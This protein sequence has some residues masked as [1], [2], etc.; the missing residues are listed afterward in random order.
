M[1]AS[2][3]LRVAAAQAALNALGGFWLPFVAL[4]FLWAGLQPSEYGLI[5]SAGLVVRVFVTPLAGIAADALRDR[6][7][8]GAILAVV[9]CGLFVL[10]ALAAQWRLGFWPILFAYTAA[11]AVHASV[12][13]II[14]A[15]T[16]RAAV[17]YG[18]TF[19][20]VR[21][22]GSAT[23]VLTTVIGG[24]YVGLTGPG[25]FMWT[26]AGFVLVQAIVFVN[27][28]PLR[29]ERDG[30]APA[31]ALALR[32]TF[33]DLGLLVSNRVFLAFL[34][35]T[36]LAQASHAVF[37]YFGTINFER[38]GFSTEYVGVLFGAGVV[39]EVL[40]LLAA[41]RFQK[42]VGPA[43][44]MLAGLA[45]AV[46]RWTGMSFDTGPWGALALQMLHAGTFGLVYLGTMQFLTRAVPHSLSASAQSLYAVIS[47]G[48]FMAIA[49]MIGG[50][51]YAQ[52]GATAYL[53]MAGLAVCAIGFTILLDRLWDGRLLFET[54]ED[55]P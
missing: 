23:F 26:V 12:G 51:V 1:N 44:L 14:E 9:A 13:P 18:F 22:I 25:L 42:H 45:C 24:W 16:A 37:Y 20:R 10:A 55:H 29:G 53:A 50:W 40:L 27:L 49:T 7:L 3:T 35:A 33:A 21:A 15:L 47:F 41:P 46:L 36:G 30:T 19:A 11:A 2:A 39:F 31:L 5:I 52:A 32:R 17:Q 48:L 34:C 38:Q 6:R 54:E 8:V 43:G 4:W 28:P